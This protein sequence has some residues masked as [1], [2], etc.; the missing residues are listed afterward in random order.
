MRIQFLRWPLV[1]FVSCL[2]C[3]THAHAEDSSE[4]K[5]V[6][7]FMDA[8][9]SG[10]VDRIMGYLAPDCHYANYPSLTGSDPVV[11]GLD[12]IRAFLTPFFRKDPLTVPFKFHT[13][14]VN[15]V[16]GAEGVA[17][18]RRDVFETGNL[19]HSVPVAGFFRVK[20][21]KITYWVDY[22]D[23]GAFQPITTIMSVYARP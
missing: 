2:L 14:I 4:A 6:R 17:I 3:V 9:H 12:N 11:K 1:L 18:E 20:D 22:F 13:E 10:D 5:V 23:S 16:G 15:V 21:G 8:W 7:A 19:K